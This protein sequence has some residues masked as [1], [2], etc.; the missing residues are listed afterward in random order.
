[1]EDQNALPS[2]KK[3]VATTQI[4][5]D[6]PDL[7]DDTPEQEL[8]TFKRASDEVLASRKIVKVCKHNSSTATAI[9]ANP[10]VGIHLVPPSLAAVTPAKATT[11]VPA[12][13]DKD[14][15]EEVDQKVEEKK[16]NEVT[17]ESAKDAGTGSDFNNA[18]AEG[19]GN[20][21]TEIPKHATV[22]EGVGKP[23]EIN[24]GKELEGK[25]GDNGKESQGEKADNE[26]ESKNVKFEDDKEAYNGSFVSPNEAAPLS[27]FQQHSSSQNAFTGLVGTG[28]S[29][30]L[31]GS[32][33]DRS[34]IPTFSFASSTSGSRP[35][36]GA[37]AAF[38][39]VAEASGSLAMKVVP[40]ETGEEDEETVF[41]ANAVLF[42]FVDGGWKERGKGELKVNVSSSG[43]KERARLVMRTRGNLRLILNASLYPD[44]K[45]ADIDKRAISFA[46][47][48]TTTE[49]NDS[50]T[51]YALKFK[52][53][54]SVKESFSSAV[55]AHKGEAA[56]P[57]NTDETSVEWD[58][59]GRLTGG[60][61]LA[62]NVY[63]DA[64]DHRTFTELLFSPE[65]LE[66][67][68]GCTAPIG[69]IGGIGASGAVGGRGG[70][71]QSAM[72]A[73]S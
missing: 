18:A 29:T 53:G 37:A 12:G 20:I 70:V 36:F 71:V 22:D 16:D 63:A 6:N 3:R 66:F 47:V 34:S 62:L 42:E 35:L 7:D 5:K 23:D 21:K 69:A 64:K 40:V 73:M 49:K 51:T 14:T 56:Q 28:F 58:P 27:S 33:A 60:V 31:F 32:N 41:S 61:C 52:D 15:D 30:F 38:V 24:D 11:D 45:L 39:P 26:K 1:M 44:M 10:F 65:L 2:L 8:G 4:S 57:A 55:A 67:S 17:V 19:N 68:E 48:N 72:H 50:L 9:S 54:S 13:K 25:K 43:E 59:G 46:C